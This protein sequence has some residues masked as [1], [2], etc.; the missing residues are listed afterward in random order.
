[1]L[2]PLCSVLVSSFLGYEFMALFLSKRLDPISVVGIGFPFGIILSGWIFFISSF[3]Y[4]LTSQHGFIHTSIELTIAL[5]I[6]LFRSF[7]KNQNKLLDPYTYIFGCIIPGTIVAWFV[8]TGLLDKGNK[9][10]GSAYGDLPFHLNLI[11]SFAH[12]C[13]SN[14]KRMFDLVSPFFANEPLSYPFIP[15][16]YSA[17]LIKCYGATL[18]ESLYLPSIIFSYATFIILTSIT[19]HFSKSELPCIFV[20]YLFLFS[21][22]L[23]FTSWFDKDAR[24]YY[25]TDYVHI[26]GEN[27]SEFW[28]Q[29]LIHIMLPQRASLFSLPI[30][31]SVILI[32]MSCA[33]KP[34]KLPFLAAGLLVGILPQVQPHSIIA[35]AE[36]GGLLFLIQFPFAEV[37]KWKFYISNYACLGI[38]ALLLGIAQCLPFMDRLSHNFFKIASVADEIEGRNIVSLW[39]YG[40]GAFIVLALV[41]VPIVIDSRQ[42]DFYAPSIIAFMLANVIYYQPWG[43]DNT[44][45]LNAAFMPIATS[46]VAYFFGQVWKRYR[47]IGKIVVALLFMFC[48]ASGALSISKAAFMSSNNLWAAPEIPYAI[49]SFVKENTDPNAVF[50]T[51]SNHNNPIVSLAGRQTLVGYPGWLISHNLN[52]TER[53]EAIEHLAEN[54]DDVEWADKYNVS[55]VVN[56]KFGKYNN[57][58]IS[59]KPD[60]PFWK[61]IYRSSYY[62]IY[63]RIK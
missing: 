16:F 27:H 14:R 31:W 32:L 41:H 33:S 23:G 6:L 3:Y 59:P 5:I 54:P 55:Y 47:S 22:G 28:F 43:L 9:T 36:W 50:I 18:H 26:W 25:S 1:M 58:K 29:S 62:E 56:Y 13:N 40:L 51:D 34:N 48:C 21:G 61:P 63:Q 24:D 60:S 46:G 4:P 10:R 39:W 12:G 2:V 52:E 30:C 15:N 35:L 57:Y 20:S 45:I 8:Y 7:K 49:S 38:P 11:S 44:K 42:W 37:H 53:L 19:Y 17:T